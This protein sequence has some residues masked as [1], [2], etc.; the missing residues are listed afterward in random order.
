MFKILNKNT[1]NKGNFAVANNS[2][3]LAKSNIKLSREWQNI[4]ILAEIAKGDYSNAKNYSGY[5]GLYKELQ[6]Q[7]VQKALAE[8]L[9]V[10]EWESLRKSA[11]TAY[12]T[13]E[14]IIRYCWQIVEQLGF[15]SGDILE[16]SCG[17]GSFFDYMP[18]AIRENSNITG[19]ELEKVSAHIASALYD[20]I[21]I[22]NDGYQNH[23]A[24]YDL[25]IGNPPYA[26]FSVNDRHF[27]DLS[28]LKIHHA[29][30]A[31]SMR[32]LR[33]GGLCVM[34][35][36][37]Y[38]LDSSSSHARDIIAKEA[39]LVCSYRL[40]DSLFS[41]AKVTVDIVVFQK[42]VK[43]KNQYL[44]LT[45]IELSCGYKDVI[46]DY[47]IEHQDHILGELE[48]Y[49]MYLT[50]EKRTRQG[51]KVTGS[52][53]EVEKRLPELIA[54]LEPVYQSNSAVKGVS[55]GVVKFKSASNTMASAK[56]NNS[57]KGLIFDIQQRIVALSVE[58]EEIAEELE[59]IN[60]QKVA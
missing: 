31:R 60:N 52:M 20:D 9:S 33:D 28:E 49:E 35:V 25:I 38:C 32:L 30:L 37:C 7:D 45:Q 22:I 15:T 27:N 46:S 26:T 57:V 50:K 23:K 11:S 58:L 55:G 47:Y 39:E 34:V 54:Q 53:E 8:I 5:G 2:Q 48:K 51:L 41:D 36:P 59:K 3:S 21:E 4:E 13:P 29:F 40:P 12:Y 42:K 44:G 6:K 18:E 24:E 19:I 16:P 56:V 14:P 1:N 17:V 43:P 10:E